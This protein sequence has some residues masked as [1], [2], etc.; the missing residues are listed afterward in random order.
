MPVVSYSFSSAVSALMAAV[1]RL[2]ALDTDEG[3]LGNLH[4]RWPNVDARPLDTGAF[5]TVDLLPA[6]A[7]V[8]TLG[9]SGEDEHVGLVQLGLYVPV[10]TGHGTLLAMYDKVRS[11]FSA[12]TMFYYMGQRVTALRVKPSPLTKSGDKMCLFASV[13]YRA[14]IQRGQ[15]PAVDARELDPGITE[16]QSDFLLADNLVSV[17]GDGFEGYTLQLTA[18][19]GQQIEVGRTIWIRQ[20][21]DRQVSIV[22][23]SPLLLTP[24]VPVMIATSGPGTVVELT[25]VTST[26]FLLSG[27]IGYVTGPGR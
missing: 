27:A 21:A 22:L 11:Y 10:N 9:T 8:A 20:G 6:D 19:V 17:A 12:G 7:V 2:N 23:E 14:L 3:G 1:A 24:L 25:R 15:S 5:L 18:A 26:V 16:Y 13:Y 4:V